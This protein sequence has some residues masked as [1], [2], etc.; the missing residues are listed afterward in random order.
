MNG[1]INYD[2]VLAADVLYSPAAH[3]PLLRLLDATVASG[4]V[5][6]LAVSHRNHG[7]AVDEATLCAA[8][9]PTTHPFFRRA[10]GEVDDD[11]A[12]GMPDVPEEQSRWSATCVF[13]FANVEILEMLRV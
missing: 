1:A 11:A 2:V 9:T 4:G 5:A 3:A 8:A 6:L 7:Q 13:L 12:A 10:G